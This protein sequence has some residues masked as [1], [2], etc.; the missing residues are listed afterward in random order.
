MFIWIWKKRKVRQ[1]ETET[2]RENGGEDRSGHARR[3]SAAAAA[4]RNDDNEGEPRLPSEECA[5]ETGGK[6]MRSQCGSSAGH[7]GHE[8]WMG[9]GRLCGPRGG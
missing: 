5:E 1:R 8:D 3:R 4:R 2:E 6:G 7:G 9:T